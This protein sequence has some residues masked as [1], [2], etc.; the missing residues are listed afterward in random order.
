MGRA[1]KMRNLFWHACLAIGLFVAAPLSHAEPFLISDA[2]PTSRKKPTDF[3]IVSGKLKFSVPAEK[4]ADGA[5]RL[6]FDLAKLPDGEHTIEIRAVN[7]NKKAR[8]ESIV[9]QAKVV[10]DGKE[11]VLL[12]PV[13][14]SAIDSQAT[15]ELEPAKDKISPSRNIR[16]IL[17]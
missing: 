16:G 9:V 5:V 8:M 14:K 6:R 3:D 2:Y 15:K 7:N 17:R 1:K 10:K 13:L 4:L 12:S 11:V